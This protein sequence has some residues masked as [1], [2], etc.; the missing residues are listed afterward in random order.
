M[1]LACRTSTV[2]VTVSPGTNGS[3]VKCYNADHVNIVE[4]DEPLGSAIIHLVP[5]QQTSKSIVVMGYLI[6]VSSRYFAAHV[7]LCYLSKTYHFYIYLVLPHPPII[8]IEQSCT[9]ITVQWGPSSR[10][11][12]P[13]S[14]NVTVWSKTTVA[15]A[16]NVIAMGTIHYSYT[17]PGLMSDVLY[18]VKVIAINCAGASEVNTAVWTC[19]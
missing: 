16:I 3:E 5:A 13:S 1:E 10:G 17:L 8:S 19:W 15:G 7:Y 9:E 12:D 4:S 14:Y 11:G 6:Y 2:S 18:M